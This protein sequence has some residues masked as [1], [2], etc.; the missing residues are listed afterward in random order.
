MDMPTLLR[1]AKLQDSICPRVSVTLARSNQ[2]AI[3][4]STLVQPRRRHPQGAR[5]LQSA[6]SGFADPHTSKG[7]QLPAPVCWSSPPRASVAPSTHA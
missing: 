2:L 6:F 1:V 4:R 3:K 5:V 7:E